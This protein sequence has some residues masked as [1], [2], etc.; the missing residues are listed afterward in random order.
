MTAKTQAT[1]T[2]RTEAK[3]T[4]NSNFKDTQRQQ[5]KARTKFGSLHSGGESAA[6]GRD[7]ASLG[8]GKSRDAI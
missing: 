7:G 5:A 2:A 8:R 4:A 1:A 6:F 3:A